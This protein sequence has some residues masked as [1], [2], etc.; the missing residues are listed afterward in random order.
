MSDFHDRWNIVQEN[1][2]WWSLIDHYVTKN[3]IQEAA[4]ERRWQEREE[5]TAFGEGEKLKYWGEKNIDEISQIL[6]EKLKYSK[7]NHFY[8]IVMK[9]LSWGAMRIQK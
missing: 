1:V 6:R 7:E 8:Y 9:I 3:A 5:K 4:E 2:V